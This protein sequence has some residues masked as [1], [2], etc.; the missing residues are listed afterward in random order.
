[1]HRVAPLPFLLA[2]ACSDPPPP[3]QAP[4]P[5]VFTVEG[6][7][8][9]A[10]LLVFSRTA[11]FRHDSI[12]DAV[13]AL[14]ELARQRGWSMTAT[15]D[16]SYFT[17]ENLAAHGAVVFLMTTGDVLNGQQEAAVENF[18][19][20]GKG[21]VGVHSASDTEYNWDWYGALVGSFFKAHSFVVSA[22]VTVEDATQP[23][24]RG[25]PSPWTR[26]DEWYAFA[27][28]PRP[29][30]SVLLTV[31]ETS[32]DPGPGVMG[33][34]HPVAWQRVFDGGRSFYTSLG[35]TRE[36]YADPIFMGHL[37][38]GIEWALGL[39]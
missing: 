16:A 13:A 6:A 11:A 15:E 21:Y 25:L 14:L 36:S 5:K 24:T 26:E 3:A 29:W 9:A 18:I 37:S 10:N 32:Y 12:E 22:R 23:P 33:Q 1:M 34:D 7:P 20:A 27:E 39:R 31:D 28:N 8:G 4:P 2:L 38:G 35:H 17:D 30:V 19:R